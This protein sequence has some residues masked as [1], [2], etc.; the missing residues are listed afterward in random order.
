MNPLGA[1]ESRRLA[2]G[3][4]A[5]LTSVEW[6]PDGKHLLLTAAGEG[7]ALHTY[8]MDL[9]GGKRQAVGPP[10]F[11]GVA[12]SPDGK[13]IAGRHVAG[14]AFFWSGDAEPRRGSR[15]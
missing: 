11:L 1:G 9:D 6:F 8:E 10:D 15:R 5:T 4:I 14:N 2:V 12:V 7:R 3:E 13:R